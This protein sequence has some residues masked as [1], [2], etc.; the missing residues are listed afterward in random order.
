MFA[1]GAYDSIHLS[2]SILQ[3]TQI[4]AETHTQALYVAWDSYN[5]VEVQFVGPK[6]DRNST[7]RPA[8]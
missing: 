6:G 5:K 7:G 8:I 1:E 3:M 2:G 4:V